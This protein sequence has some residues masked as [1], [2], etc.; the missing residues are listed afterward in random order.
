MA[1]RPFFGA[2]GK[3]PHGKLHP[4]DE[5]ELQFGVATDGK[6]VLIQF[7]KP[8]AWLGLPP[9]KARALA[10]VLIEHADRID[11]NREAGSSGSH[12][13]TPEGGKL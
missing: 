7:G 11:G 6:V 5:G 2:T 4:S 1:F 13:T 12:P 8:I 9:D 10:K 3:F